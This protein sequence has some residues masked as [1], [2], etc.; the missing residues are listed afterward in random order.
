MVAK[1][2]F[3]GFWMANPRY[4]STTHPS[5]L[6]PPV[7]AHRL[8]R[9]LLLSRMGWVGG[10]G[11]HNSLPTCAENIQEKRLKKLGFQVLDVFTYVT[12]FTLCYSIFQVQ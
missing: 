2:F 8:L 10:P 11:H 3:L 9:L 7:Q 12:W 4:L 6:S 1:M 5:L